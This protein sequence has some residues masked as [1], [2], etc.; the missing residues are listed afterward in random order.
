M[1]WVISHAISAVKSETPHCHKTPATSGAG[2]AAFAIPAPS[3]TALNPSAPT[4]AVSAA[5]FFR[6]I[7]KLL[8]QPPS[9]CNVR[10]PKFMP[11][12]G[13]L[14]RSEGAAISLGPP[15]HLQWR[16][17]LLRRRPS[18]LN[19]CAFDAGCPN[20]QWGHHRASIDPTTGDSVGLESL[21]RPIIR[22]GWRADCFG[23]GLAPGSADGHKVASDLGKLASPKG[24][25]MEMHA[26][27]YPR[28]S[29]DA[30]A[31]PFCW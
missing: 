15:L 29:D 14:V 24:A 5:I 28:G 1:S 25:A 27:N 4:I 11:T 12:V 22:F 30:I 10:Q 17:S 18:P 13:D 8:R 9:S 23:A 21:P 2:G 19:R 31:L 7:A 3:P 16:E 26:A 20:R 6:N